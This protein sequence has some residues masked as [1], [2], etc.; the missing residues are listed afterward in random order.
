MFRKIARRTLRRLGWDLHRLPAPY[1]T[2]R[3]LEFDLPYLL[4]QDSPRIIDVGANKGQTI[5][6]VRRTLRNPK[7]VSF[8]AN[9]KM[10]EV[11]QKK[12]GASGVQLE[13]CAVGSAN[14]HVRFAVTENDELSS[15]L[16]LDRIET[17]PFAET[18]TCSRINVAVTTL[19]HYCEGRKLQHIDLLKSDTQGYDLEVLKGAS[20]LLAGKRI[21]LILVEV[22]FIRLYENQC[23]FGQ[24]ERFLAGRGYGLLAL[25]E[26]VR[27]K[28]CVSWATACFCR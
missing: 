7:I 22:N 24:I 15:V 19:D 3:D 6:L 20:S 4:A 1:L 28:R 23:N 18:R 9:P 26:V 21:E 14:G 2:L 25:Y 13:S 5:D 10:A 16:E 8:E 11:L 12:Y 17:N 27:H